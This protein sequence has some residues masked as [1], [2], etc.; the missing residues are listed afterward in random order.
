MEAPFTAR[1]GLLIVLVGVFAFSALAVLSA[2]APDLRGGDNGGAHALSRSAIGYAGIVRAL[3]LEGDP[4]L[5][6][7]APTTGSQGAGL[8]VVTPS[9]AVDEDNVT[10]L[11]FTG[12]VLVVL[13]KMVRAAGSAASRVGRQR[14]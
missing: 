7:R 10:A 3:K 9:P 13:P 14:A 2:Y 6:N 1:S 12:S 8:M 5:V 4:V 11:G